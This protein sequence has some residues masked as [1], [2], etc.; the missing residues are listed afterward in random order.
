[1]KQYTDLEFLRLSKWQRFQ[2]RF[3]SFFVAIPVAIWHFILGIGRFLKK[4]GSAVANEAKDIWTT[5]VDGDWKTKISYLVMGF[6]CIARGQFLRGI[7]FLLFEVVFIGYM[8]L[9]GGSYL[10]LLPTLGTKG[11]YQA[12]VQ[13]EGAGRLREVT[14]TVT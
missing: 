3:I 9:L 7:L 12:K 2:H 8:V 10:G 11:P 13:V 1:M 14:K 6:G 4:A 5:F